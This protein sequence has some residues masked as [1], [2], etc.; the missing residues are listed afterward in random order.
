[1]SLLLQS[2]LFQILNFIDYRIVNLLFPMW[3]LLCNRFTY[4]LIKGK[5]YLGSQSKR[6]DHTWNQSMV[7]QLISEGNIRRRERKESPMGLMAST[8][9]KFAR[10]FS[11]K[12]LYIANGVF[13]TRLPYKIRTISRNPFEIQFL[14]SPENVRDWCKWWSGVMH[15]LKSQLVRS[16]SM[17]PFQKA[18]Q[19]K[20]TYSF[21]SIS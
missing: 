18:H 5:T 4:S 20:T 16:F 15:C 1:M 3:L 6:S 19:V 2:K 17:T 7:Q 11:I 14:R 10:T 9:C 21:H 13:S 12:Q 8:M